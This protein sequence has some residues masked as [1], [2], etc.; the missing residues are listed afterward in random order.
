MAGIDSTAFGATVASVRLDPADIAIGHSRPDPLKGLKMTSP[1]QSIIEAKMQ[2]AATITG[3]L[4]S[5]A[6]DGT[7]TI[8]QMANSPLPNDAVELYRAVIA[9]LNG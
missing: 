7:E 3:A 2:V 9:A 6:S 8:K 5:Q 4:I 1:N